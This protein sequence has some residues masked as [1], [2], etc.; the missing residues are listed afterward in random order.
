MWLT[1][2]ISGIVG[3]IILVGFLLLGRFV[4]AGAVMLIVLLGLW[5]YYHALSKASHRPHA[6]LGMAGGVAFC[7]GALY[8]GEAGLGLALVGLLGAGFLSM[9][10][11]A[12]AFGDLAFTFTGSAYVGALLAH[13]ILIRDLPIG[14]WGVL[15]V[16]VATWTYDTSAYVVGSTLGRRP[17]APELSPNKTIAGAVGATVL[18]TIVMTFFFLLPGAAPGHLTVPLVLVKG[19][20]LGLTIA[21]V[22][23]LGDLSESKFKRDLGIKDTGTLIPGHGGVLDRF[24]SLIFTGALSYYI[25]RYFF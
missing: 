17:L 14:V 13:L 15:A 9:L 25:L 1:R 24:D 7:V 19:S 6:F 12:M 21:L 5:E 8:G 23:P 16:F 11:G 3:I 18:T 2:V 22:A 20:F 4:F 10:L